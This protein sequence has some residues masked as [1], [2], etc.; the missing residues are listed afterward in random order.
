MQ[1][2]WIDWK[3]TYSNTEGSFL[4]TYNL[5]PSL[6]LTLIM[7]MLFTIGHVKNRS[8]IS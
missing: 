2:N 3:A 8:K 5:G 6:V 7:V 1:N 4:T